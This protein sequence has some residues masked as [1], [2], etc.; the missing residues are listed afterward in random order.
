MACVGSTDEVADL[1]IFPDDTHTM[2]GMMGH[3][4]RLPFLDSHWVI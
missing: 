3:E 2:L 4:V 1:P